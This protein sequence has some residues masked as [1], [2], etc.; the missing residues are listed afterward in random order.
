MVAQIDEESQG[1]RVISRALIPF[2]RPRTI[3]F[4]GHGFL[5]RT[6]LYVFFDNQDVNAFVTPLSST[7]TTDT[8]IVAGSPLIS[9]ASGKIEGTFAIP[10]YKF[11]GQ[12]SAPK[13][14]T[15]EVEFRMT[16]SATNLR[17][18]FAGVIKQ[19]STAGTAIYFAKGILET[20][21][22]TIIATR[23]AIITTTSV[24][25]TTSNTSVSSVDRLFQVPPPD[26]GRSGGR[27]DND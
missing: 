11:P 3:T 7:Y 4:S 24:S 16:S 8:T 18:G 1:S 9:T 19:P 13:F 12:T 17:A 21:Q 6:R 27:N 23:N 10:D 15:G 2:V 22:E 25:G 20:E 26:N 5:P 14:R